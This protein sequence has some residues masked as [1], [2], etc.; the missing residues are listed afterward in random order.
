MPVARDYMT[1]IEG[2]NWAS[3]QNNYI[4]ISNNHKIV[5]TMCGIESILIIACKI[6]NAHA[7][8]LYPGLDVAH[9]ASEFVGSP[10]LL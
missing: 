10:L 1:L 8:D 7:L 2:C 6:D 5:H 4:N 9:T 3:L